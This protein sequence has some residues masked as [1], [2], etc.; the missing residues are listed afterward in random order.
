MVTAEVTAMGTFL[1]SAGTA[2][3]WVFGKIATVADA[4]VSNPILL[5]TTGVMLAGAVVGIFGRLL[6][7]N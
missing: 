2:V 1:E 3:T 4:I 7:K 6:S 5:V